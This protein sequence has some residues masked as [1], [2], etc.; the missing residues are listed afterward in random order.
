MLLLKVSFSVRD[1]T[2]RVQSNDTVQDG[3]VSRLLIPPSVRSCRALGL[4]R[5]IDA[6]APGRLALVGKA[7]QRNAQDMSIAN[8]EEET[9]GDGERE[10]GEE[11]MA[12][13]RKRNMRYGRG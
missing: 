10:R 3:V 1:A 9:W 7:I 6:P 5:A 8:D 13:G 12:E 2:G 11:L 4:V